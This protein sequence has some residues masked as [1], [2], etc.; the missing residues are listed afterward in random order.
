[1][2][3]FYNHV[4]ILAGR[5]RRPGV[6]G[7]LSWVACWDPFSSLPFLAL[8]VA[9]IV[10]SSGLSGPTKSKILQILFARDL[11]PTQLGTPSAA[12]PLRERTQHAHTFVDEAAKAHACR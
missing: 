10:L 11:R 5:K 12:G 7:M 3:M 9:A 6:I 4:T 1:M 8:R 2:Y